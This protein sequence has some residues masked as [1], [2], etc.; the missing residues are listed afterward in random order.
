MPTYQQGNKN[1]STG[2]TFPPPGSGGCLVC[3]VLYQCLGPS[4]YGAACADGTSQVLADTNHFADPTGGSAKVTRMHVTVRGEAESCVNPNATVNIW[5]QNVNTLSWVFLGSA[6]SVGN[7]ICSCNACNANL[8]DLDYVNPS[9]IPNYN[10]NGG[11]MLIRVRDATQVMDVSLVD[12]TVYTGSNYLRQVQMVGSTASL[13]EY[14]AS[15]TPAYLNGLGIDESSGGAAVQDIFMSSINDPNGISN[16]TIARWDG[17]SN[18]VN[19]NPGPLPMATVDGAAQQQFALKDYNYGPVGPTSDGLALAS[20]GRM[21]VANYMTNG[22][23][24]KLTYS[25]TGL[26]PYIATQLIT[27]PSPVDRISAIDFPNPIIP[28]SGGSD[29]GDNILRVARRNTSSGST[30]N[31]ILFIDVNGAGAGPQL[32]YTLDLN[33][34]NEPGASSGGV[35]S[36]LYNAGLRNIHSVV[37]I[38]VD[39]LN[40]TNA[41]YLEVV[42][43]VN[44]SAANLAHYILQVTADHAVRPLVDYNGIIGVLRQMDTTLNGPPAAGLTGEGRITA[45]AQERMYRIV[46]ADPGSSTNTLSTVQYFDLAP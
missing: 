11:Q 8:F 15:F 4:P 5:L 33:S 18:V 45:G 25:A 28:P 13:T 43:Y 42:E 24:Y 19:L 31:E 16:P 30:H 46:P 10:Y 23:V 7:T 1:L 17:N 38:T 37:S 27:L 32:V 41:T 44:G 14:P 21:F 22:D 6:T 3:G 39:P 12:I 35:G 34:A 40:G 2:I 36:K 29:L 26:P 9:G 20:G